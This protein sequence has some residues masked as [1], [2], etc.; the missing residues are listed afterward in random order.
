MLDF[1]PTKMKQFLYL[2]AATIF[3]FAF[4]SNCNGQRDTGPPECSFQ[5]DGK[6]FPDLTDCTRY[7]VC[8]SEKP[9]QKECPIDPNST[10]GTK[11]NYDNFDQVR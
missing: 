8:I 5:A 7:Y 11:L 9:E 2:S 10:N 1:N 4:I 3:L 6:Q